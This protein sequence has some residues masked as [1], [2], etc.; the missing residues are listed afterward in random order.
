MKI[1]TISSCHS[2]LGKTTLA[3]KI[4][5]TLPN[6]IVLKIGHAENKDKPEALFHS[7]KDALAQIKDYQQNKVYDYLIIES[8]SILDHLKPEADS[9]EGDEVVV[10]KSTDD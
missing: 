6:S 2:N 4:K 10:S 8:N 3:R 9:N 1:I 7:L 5:E